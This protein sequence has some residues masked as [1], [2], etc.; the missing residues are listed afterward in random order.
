MRNNL[1]WNPSTQVCQN[2]GFGSNK[3]T[4]PALTAHNEAFKNT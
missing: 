2:T 3:S 4:L 1:H